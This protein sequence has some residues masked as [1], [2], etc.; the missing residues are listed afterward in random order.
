MKRKT[1][2]MTSFND[3]GQQ[4]V[5]YK[6]WYGGTL[7]E[8]GQLTEFNA[9]KE[10]GTHDEYNLAKA[11]I[12]DQMLSVRPNTVLREIDDEF[13]DTEDGETDEWN[14]TG[15]MMNQ[16]EDTFV[17]QPIGEPSVRKPF[18]TFGGSG[19]GSGSESGSGSGSGTS[20]KKVQK[21][22]KK[23]KNDV[24]SVTDDEDDF[25]KQTT[26]LRSSLRKDRET[27][28]AKETK[29][30]KRT[31]TSDDRREFEEYSS[32]RRNKNRSTR[33]QVQASRKISL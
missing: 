6:P 3:F 30:R 28:S 32:A 33:P 15:G 16:N 12:A 21:T 7:Y 29:R 8:Q 19:S 24:G 22:K 14:D 23:K 4:P 31:I 11:R 1:K 2:F 26:K 18:Y 13:Y 5:F 17:R 9:N 20:R 27:K 25:E 10:R